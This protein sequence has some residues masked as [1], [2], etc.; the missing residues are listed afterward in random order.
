MKQIIRLLVAS[1]LI[2]SGLSAVEVVNNEKTKL[3]IN[4]RFQL[5]G[6]VQGLDDSARDDVRAFMFLK[7]ARVYI[8]GQ[9]E[10]I[11]FRVELGL[12]GE[13][14]ITNGNA[15][16]SLLDM[17]A[18]MPLL[19]GTRFRFGQTKVPYGRERLVYSRDLQFSNR[20]QVN[21]TFTLDR[22]VGGI[23]YGNVDMFTL[24]VG[25]FAGGGRDVPERYLPEELGSPMMVVRMGLN[26]GAD[27]D[28]LTVES[29]GVSVDK[30]VFGFYLN[31]MYQKNSLVGHSTVA[32]VKLT[33]K[34]LLVNSNWNPYLAEKPFALGALQQVS[35]DMI[36]RF[37]V[38]SVTIATELEAHYAYYSNT[39]GD[40]NVPGARAQV[41]AYYKPVEVALRY[42]AVGLQGTG[43]GYYNS[44]TS[45][46]NSI[47]PNGMNIMQELAL[48]FTMYA[49]TNLKGIV[50]FSLADVPVVQEKGIGA[51]VVTQQP[52]QV[53]LAASSNNKFERQTVK[54]VRVLLQ[55]WF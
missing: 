15:S 52:D 39:F 29:S 3:D 12:G 25:L 27:T 37:P 35:T 6:L 50:D 18:D 48:A 17:Y 9:H 55:Y 33:E 31:G 19:L 40:L 23:A 36:V 21:S 42:S 53:K 46:V 49:R 2:V 5:L 26:G 7:Q 54:E 11:K 22:D 16:V 30:F 10:D 8:P 51:Y 4:G 43:F 13:D 1:L 28:V 44:G 14:D 24:A 38:S 34:S 41:S 47:V 20:S 32:N 45:K